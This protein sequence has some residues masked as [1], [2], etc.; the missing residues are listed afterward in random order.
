M[1]RM[2]AYM[3]CDLN[4]PVSVQYTDVSIKSFEPV[5]DLIEII[6]VQCFVP[7]TIDTCP[8][9]FKISAISHARKYKG[10]NRTIPPGERACLTSHIHQWF[11][12]AATPERFIIMEHDAYLKDESKFRSLFARVEEFEIWN[13]GIAMECYSMSHRFARYMRLY[14]EDDNYEAT[15]GPMGEIFYLYMKLHKKRYHLTSGI[16]P[17]LWPNIYMRNQIVSS[18]GQNPATA[19]RTGMF[20][21]AP[22]TQCF[23][24]TI[25]STIEHPLPI[26]KKTNPDVKY[27]T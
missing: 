5:S 8:H 11:E 24:A 20:E 7:D 23:D 10:Q 18:H 14:L 26:N 21:S 16:L 17:L 27:L 9:K 3:I 4:N 25:G 2:K 13:C 22:V 1:T 6:K 19:I 12:Q 15:S